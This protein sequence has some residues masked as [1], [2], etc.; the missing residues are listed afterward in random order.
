MITNFMVLSQTLGELASRASVLL[1]FTL[2]V[3]EA[4]VALSLIIFM[5]RTSHSGDLGTI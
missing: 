2:S 1:F 3:A 4:C 5:A